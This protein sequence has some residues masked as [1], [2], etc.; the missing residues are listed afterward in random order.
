MNFVFS[1]IQG[2]PSWRICRIQIEVQIQVQ[3]EVQNEVQNEVQIEVQIEVQN[4]VQIEV[5]NEVQIE[6]Q[7]EV[8][9]HHEKDDGIPCI[10]E[11]VRFPTPPQKSWNSIDFCPAWPPPAILSK[12]HL[13]FWKFQEF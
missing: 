1:N 11:N 8:S 4:E 13:A 12:S 2:I 5:Q 10:F 6:V 3:I 9:K 7:I